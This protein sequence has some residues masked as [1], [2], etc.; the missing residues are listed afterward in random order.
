MTNY[1]KNLL[2]ITKIIM[3]IKLDYSNSIVSLIRTDMAMS[4]LKKLEK[5]LQNSEF[6]KKKYGID[7]FMLEGGG[8]LHFL[9]KK[10]PTYFLL[11]TIHD[12]DFFIKGDSKLIKVLNSPDSLKEV[13]CVVQQ[14]FS[15]I[16]SDNM[17]FG[18]LPWHLLNKQCKDEVKKKGAQF[19]MFSK[20][21]TKS[22]IEY[23]LQ[24][25][26]FDLDY[27]K[28]KKEIPEAIDVTIQIE[29]Q[30]YSPLELFTPINESGKSQPT[31]KKSIYLVV[32]NRLRFMI[33]KSIRSLRNPE[34][35]FGTKY[36]DILDMASI[37]R[38]NIPNEISPEIKE[39]ARKL[40]LHTLALYADYPVDIPG[41]L[42]HTL[43]L[44]ILYSDDN[45]IFDRLFSQ[46][47]KLTCEL[48]SSQIH[49]NDFQDG[50]S[51][52]RKLLE[53]LFEIEP[54]DGKYF[55]KLTPT[56]KTLFL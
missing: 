50:L 15:S 42:N 11:R 31:N 20:T 39:Q 22:E 38:S 48:V 40:F 5:E 16:S 36:T 54:I 23:I 26:I 9:S 1:L 12:L 33:E 29:F 45:K 44:D 14:I 27:E 46:T 35:E 43:N 37:H 7:Y 6:I 24:R 10:I 4:I 34:H 21:Y 51:E 49:I 18:D 8:V 47:K 55:L 19:F 13:Q 30:Y 41:K 28:I 53:S 25:S 17:Q 3:E 56:E 2:F 32:P 52:I